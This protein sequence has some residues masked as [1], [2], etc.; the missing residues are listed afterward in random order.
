MSELPEKPAGTV[1]ITTGE[2]AA[3]AILRPGPVRFLPKYPDIKVELILDYGL[4]GSP[5]RRSRV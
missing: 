5:H 1:H 2:H 3:D 4:T